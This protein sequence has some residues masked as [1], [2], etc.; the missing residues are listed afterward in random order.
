MQYDGALQIAIGGSNLALATE[1]A[2]RARSSRTREMQWTVEMAEQVRQLP[3]RSSTTTV[4]AECTE[5][6]LT[7]DAV[8]ELKPIGPFDAAIVESARD[9]RW[10]SVG[11][12]EVRKEDMRV[13]GPLSKLEA[14]FARSVAGGE[15]LQTALVRG[16]LEG[17]RVLLEHLVELEGLATGESR[18][19]RVI[20]SD[21]G[22]LQISEIVAAG[23]ASLTAITAWL[24]SPIVLRESRRSSDHIGYR[25]SSCQGQLLYTSR[26]QEIFVGEPSYIATLSILVDRCQAP[27]QSVLASAVASVC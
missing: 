11:S 8:V 24:S 17:N 1:I 16:V 22:R 7:D 15:V 23:N 20:S 9:D 14:S 26:R 2:V 27:I 5:W 3:S 10:W 12:Y 13:V 25:F 6:Q 4:R 19:G 18:L 21:G